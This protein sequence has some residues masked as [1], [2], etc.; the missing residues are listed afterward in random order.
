MNPKYR[1]QFNDNFTTEKY[2]N[3][4]DDITSD[5][6][7]KVT[8]RIG[9]TPFFIPSDLKKQLLEASQEVIS[10]IQKEGFNELTNKALE[11]NRKVP[12]EDSHTTF[13]A[14]DFG[15]CEEDGK[16]IPKLIEVQGFPS[17][18]NFQYNL[19]EK[20]QNHYPF[21]SNLTPFFNGLSKE[22]YLQ[23]V[24]EA[25]C[26]NHPKENVVLLEIE[27]EKQNTKI[28]FYYCQRDFGVPTVCITDI[29]KKGNQLFYNNSK[30]KEILIKRI[31]NR[32]IFDELD[33]RTDLK[34]NFNF[35]DELDV[36][37]AGHPNWFFRISK[38]ILPY[39]KGKYFIE[40][41]LLSDLKEIPTDLENYVLKP[42]FSFSGTGVIFHVKPGDIESVK[43]KDLYILQKKVNYKPIIQSPDG[44][45]KAE[46]RLLAVWKKDAPSPTLVTNLVR[47]SRGEMIGVKFN[48]DKDWVGG[49]VGMFEK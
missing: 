14:I 8:F 13:L 39:L 31:Y 25:I 10:F 1:Q 28:D 45:V 35:S 4:I 12:N 41:T 6:D 36:E 20:F 5:F 48:K 19:A 49:T 11:L 34:L 33:L 30:G 32:V 18:Y 15:I 46:V 43:E 40:T 17:L 42:L 27:P 29:I 37:W 22:E 7:Y 21:L 3:F 38:F 9:E 2:D 16:I 23:I 44:K 26:N 24:E 47:L